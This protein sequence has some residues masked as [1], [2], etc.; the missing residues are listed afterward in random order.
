MKLQVLRMICGTLQAVGL[1]LLLALIVFGQPPPYPGFV[2]V[3]IGVCGF[4][5]IVSSFLPKP[6]IESD[7]DKMFNTTGAV[8]GFGIIIVAC[9]I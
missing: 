7:F 6:Y 1:I 9:V 4:A 2:P 5:P 3:L 8:A